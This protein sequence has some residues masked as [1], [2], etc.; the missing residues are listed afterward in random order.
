MLVLRRRRRQVVAAPARG[1]VLGIE[2][3]LACMERMEYAAILHH[4]QQA[5]STTSATVA[6]TMCAA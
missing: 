6:M 3:N 4:A 1:L 5:L 2:D